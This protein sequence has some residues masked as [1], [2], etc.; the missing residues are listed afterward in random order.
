MFTGIIAEVGRVKNITRDKLSVYAPEL[1]NN[2]QL[3]A[4]IAVNGTCLTVTR[5]SNE[6]FEVGISEETLR[7][8][9]MRTLKV[10]DFVNLERALEFG[11][12]LGGHLVQGHIDGT[13][14]ILQ[15]TPQSGSNMYRISA[16]NEILRYLVIKGFIAVEGISLTITDIDDK[17]FQVAIIDFTRDNTNLKYKKIG[18]PVN[19]EIDIMAKYAERFITDIKT[20]LNKNFLTENGF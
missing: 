1:L 19:L 17:T 5:F 6:E 11:G 15:I 7:R 9:S 3:G 8:T 2:I 16:Q 14:Q 18:D 4:S 12:E 20:G 13:G 10:G